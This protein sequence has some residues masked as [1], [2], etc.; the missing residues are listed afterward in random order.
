MLCNNSFIIFTKVNYPLT[1]N[2]TSNLGYH[3]SKFV[4]F[5]VCFFICPWLILHENTNPRP[6]RDEAGAAVTLPIFPTS[7]GNPRKPP[8]N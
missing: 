7:S 8:K 4:W 2:E 5:V 1:E 3:T 6:I